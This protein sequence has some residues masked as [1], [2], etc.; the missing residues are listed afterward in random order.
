MGKTRKI[1]HCHVE[2]KERQKSVVKDKEKYCKPF[3]DFESNSLMKG[4]AKASN[5]SFSGKEHTPARFLG[6]LWL[7]VYLVEEDAI[8]KHLKTYTEILPI[9][10]L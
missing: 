4:I 10:N 3:W 7:S 6:L 1:K 8:K 9:W 2:C 5:K